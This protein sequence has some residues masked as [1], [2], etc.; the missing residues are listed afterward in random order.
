[1]S[2]SLVEKYVC[3]TVGT[4]KGKIEPGKGSSSLDMI[5]D[6]HTA[7]ENNTNKAKVWFFGFFSLDVDNVGLF[8]FLVC[9]FLFCFVFLFCFPINIQLEGFKS[10]LY[11]HC[12]SKSASRIES[13][14]IRLYLLI[15]FKW[16]IPFPWSLTWIWRNSANLKLSYIPSRFELLEVD[17]S[18]KT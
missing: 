15:P 4:I 16:M 5:V 12:R 6:H 18:F 8:C 1:M 14:E 2:L 9:L 3:D 17:F 7:F 11:K 10:Q 13:F